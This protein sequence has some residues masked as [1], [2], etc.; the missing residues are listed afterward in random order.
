[1]KSADAGCL[2]F[3]L[4]LDEIDVQG[5]VAKLLFDLESFLRWGQSS[6]VGSVSE[7]K[8][9]IVNAIKRCNFF[10]KAMKTIVEDATHL[11]INSFNSNSVSAMSQTKMI[12][13]MQ[14]INEV[15]VLEMEK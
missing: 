7:V 8:E 13:T 3:E 4:G 2:S 14:T 10:E 1:M 9:V 5:G 12:S 11:V 6:E 15:G